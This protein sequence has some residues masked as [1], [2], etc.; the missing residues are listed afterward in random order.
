MHNELAIRCEHS[1]GCALSH[2]RDSAKREIDFIVENAS[3]LLLGIEVK[4]GSSVRSD[5]FV[6][7]RWF[8]DN[9]ARR[10]FVG[11]VLYTGSQTVPFGQDFHA[12]PLGALANG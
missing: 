10:K 2:Y 4:A 12:V 1:D 5:D 7:L 3:G 6:H 8:R 11:I 9:L